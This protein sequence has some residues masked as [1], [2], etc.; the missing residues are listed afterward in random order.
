VSRIYAGFQAAAGVLGLA[1]GAAGVIASTTGHAILGPV[2]PYVPAIG[3][4][5]MFFGALSLVMSFGLL[6]GLAWAWTIA[7]A[8]DALHGLGDVGTMAARG[9]NVD[10]L[11]GA[12]IAAGLV[13]YLTRPSVR[14][15]FRRPA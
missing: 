10:K 8:V 2:A 15:Y 7:L 11:I 3:A 4:A 5:L 12:A 6:R 13:Y 9:F 14:A 1:G